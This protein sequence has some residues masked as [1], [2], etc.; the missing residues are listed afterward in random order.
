MLRRSLSSDAAASLMTAF[1]RATAA[2]GSFS[3]GPNHTVA[4]G[5]PPRSTS[6]ARIIRDDS[7]VEPSAALASVLDMSIAAYSIAVSGRSEEGCR[8]TKSAS[9]AATLMSCLHVENQ[10][11]SVIQVRKSEKMAH[12]GA[13]DQTLS[14]RFELDE[15]GGEVLCGCSN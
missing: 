1:T 9:S 8:T 15:N 3:A 14:Q 12:S 5:F 10:R 4:S 13:A 2:T 6:S 7:I 11:R